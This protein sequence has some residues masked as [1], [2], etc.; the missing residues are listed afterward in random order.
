MAAELDTVFLT[1]ADDSVGERLDV[2]LSKMLDDISRSRIQQWIREG[3]VSVDEAAC[4]PSMK[5]RG[6]ESIEV[7]PAHLKPLHAFAED[8]PLD[9]LYED[10]DLAAVNKPAGMTVHAGAGEAAQSGTLVNA[11]LHHFGSSL[12]G[13]GGELR[14]GIVHRLDRWTSGVILVAKTDKGHRGLAQ[15]FESRQVKKV[16]TALTQGEVGDPQHGQRTA[17]ERPAE[18]DGQWWMRIEAPIGRDP[19]RR[20][21]MAVI[22]SGRSAVTDYRPLRARSKPSFS[23]LE[24]R[25]HTGRTHQIRVHLSWVGRPIVGDATYG[26]AADGSERFLLHASRIEIAHPV[27][28]AF[29]RIEAPLAQDFRDRLTALSL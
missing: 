27:S 9:I 14:P 17:K 15:A 16:Y 25:I 18:Q 10:N 3:R 29:L 24:V 11:L 2:Y 4:R 12:S 1:A 8:I 26:G 22:E 19:R 21:R 20:S 23:L 5:L 6:G 13:E 28:G 7:E